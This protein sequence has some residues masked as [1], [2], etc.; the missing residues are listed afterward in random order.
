MTPT[1]LGPYSITATLGRGGM[2]T[3]YEAVDETTGRAVAVKTLAT[4]LGDDPG[5]RKRFAAE[6]ETLKSL[7]HAGIVE[8][9]A[10]G[11]EEG[12]P[13]FAMELVRGRSLE[14]LLRSGRRFTWRE[15]VDTALEIARAL[16][17]AHDHGVIHRDLKPANLI[18]PDSPA[19]DSH[20]KLADFGIAKLFGGSGHT[21]AGM[22]VGTAEYMA[23]EQAAGLPVD[24]RADLYALGLVMFAMLTGRP[25]FFGGLA[26]DVIRRQRHEPAPS[27]ASRVEGVPPALDELVARLLAKDPADR[28]ASALAVGRTLAAIASAP[29]APDTPAASGATGPE[30][31]TANEAGDTRAMSRPEVDLLAPTQA[32]PVGG[33]GDAALI[34]GAATGREVTPDAQTMPMPTRGLPH[35]GLAHLPTEPA[36][37]RGPGASS[38]ANRFTTVEELARTEAA[39]AAARRRR[40]TRI[41]AVVAMLLAAAVAAGGYVLLRSPTADELHDRIMAAVS[42]PEADPRDARPLIDRFLAEHPDDPR[43]SVIRNVDRSLDLD[44]LE[45]RARR[46]RL[47]SGEMLPLEREYRA[48]MARE[49]ESPVACVAALEAILAV[50]ADDAA[51]ADRSTDP[52]AD[53]TLW[54][55]LVRR[56]IERL[57]PRAE[58]E[59]SE[60]RA[61]AAATLAEAAELAARA[62]AA[63]DP[64]ERDRLLQRRRSLLEAL[65]ELYADRPHVAEAV[66]EARSLLPAP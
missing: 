17:S 4:H 39:A 29:P 20:V 9:L 7:R 51:L 58:Q 53:P 15:T 50:H 23:P 32:F 14:Q 10:F 38:R 18:V 21:M 2:G 52:D 28:P 62:D 44:T 49:S 54:M 8:L 3:V 37:G 60:D 35:T 65:L 33:A 40:D 46:R 41:Q 66:A 31:S 57:A 36:A 59:R 25:P 1:R 30:P 27:V 11:E 43:A 34:A 26:T 6:I 45:K 56:Q 64:A 12:M 16:K 47:G 22:I 19:G 63:T 5:L 48:A 13:Y 42:G 55:A 24:Q 61:R